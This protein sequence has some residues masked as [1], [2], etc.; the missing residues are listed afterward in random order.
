VA[1]SDPLP[2]DPIITAIKLAAGACD[3]LAS[4]IPRVVYGRS[5]KLI[6]W[7]RLAALGVRAFQRRRRYGVVVFWNSISG[8][9][10]TALQRLTGER[11]PATILMGFVFVPRRR[12]VCSFVRWAFVKWGLAWSD[13]VLCTTSGE[14]E[15][16]GRLFPECSGKFCYIPY[17]VDPL[18]QTPR[19]PGN[20]EHGCTVL[21]AGKSNRDYRTFL[22]AMAGLE[23]D[24]EIITSP[25]A[26]PGGAL[27]GN[28]RVRYNVPYNQY[29]DRVRTAKVVVLPL[30]ERGVAAAQGTLLLAMALGKP[31]VVSG[32]AGVADYVEDG[33]TAVVVP[34]AQ[35]E[36]LRQ[37]IKCLVENGD[38]AARLGA[39]ASRVVNARFTRQHLAERVGILVQEIL[40]RE[41]SAVEA[42]GHARA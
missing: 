31:V 3:V 42:G 38:E 39:A 34:P 7:G 28:V 40:Q 36:A 19:A 17:T 22:R 23:Y 24:G 4:D 9:F 30:V 15:L 16:Y 8:L 5:G 32:T 1:T 14:I 41:C 20:G 10:F 29:V 35:P 11:C 2:H 37:A 27:P 13:L 12:G 26:L 33:V 21:S 25:G 6:L 18:P